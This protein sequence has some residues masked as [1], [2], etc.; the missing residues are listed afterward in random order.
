M[1]GVYDLFYFQTQY[2]PKDTALIDNDK[3]LAYAQLGERICRLAYGLRRLGVDRGSRVGYLF[4]N[5][6]SCVELFYALQKIGAV[7]I[8]FNCR[9][10]AEDIKS[11]VEMV[12]CHYFFYGEAFREIISEVRQN[13][14]DGIVFGIEGDPLPG[15]DVDYRALFAEGTEEASLS[16]PASEDSVA[17]MMFT[18]GTTGISKAVMLSGEDLYLKAT[19]HLLDDHDFSRDTV[20]LCY[21]PL[22]HVAGMTYL[23]YLMSLGG[24]LVLKSSFDVDDMLRTI[25]QKRVTHIFMIPPGLCRRLKESSSYGQV[26]LSS[27]RFIIMSGGLNSPQLV[28][29][30]F[31]MFSSQQVRIS[32]TYGHTESAADT[33]LILNRQEFE[34]NPA[35]AGAIGRMTKGSFIELRDENGKP[36]GIDCPGEAWARSPGMFAGFWGQDSPFRDGWYPTGDIL[37]QDEDGYFYF[38]DRKKDMIKSGGENIYAAEVENVLNTHPAVQECAVFGQ[39]HER[40]SE[41]VVAAVVLNPDYEPSEAELISY[42]KQYLAS[43]KKPQCIYFMDGLPRSPIGKVQKN[44]LRQKFAQQH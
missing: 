28:R 25:D 8:P 7:A 21:S 40:W 3:I 44:V 20:M 27:V 31:A 6:S 13:L 12:E 15:S 36:V 22:F 18:G 26:D 9:S 41:M 37:K 34:E 39:P 38:L 10:R 43:Y 23:L 5:G 35:L 30:V 32:N 42:C 33:I 4:A 17:L 11:L 2:R 1:I 29:E 14:K 16:C 24:T 19:L